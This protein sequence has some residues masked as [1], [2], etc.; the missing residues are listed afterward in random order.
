MS[1]FVW[2]DE[3]KQAI[4]YASSNVLISAGAGSGKTAVLT[5]RVYH[6][7]KNGADITRF[8]IL[9]FSN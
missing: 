5:E 4:E 8:L 3:Q 9:T 6:L 1:N 2:S 7:I